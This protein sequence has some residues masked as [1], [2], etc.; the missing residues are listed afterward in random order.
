MLFTKPN[1]VSESVSITTAADGLVLLNIAGETDLDDFFTESAGSY[2]VEVLD[3]GANNLQ[4]YPD[5]T[6][7]DGEQAECLLIDFV[8]M[9]SNI[10]GITDIALLFTV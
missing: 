9:G 5:G 2:V 4:I 3:T 8:D 7:T 1:G 6:F 10:A